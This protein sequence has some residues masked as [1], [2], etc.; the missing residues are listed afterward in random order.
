MRERLQL[1]IKR[2]ADGQ[3]VQQRLAVF[4]RCFAFLM[5]MAALTLSEPH[6][7]NQPGLLTGR[8][9]A[10]PPNT[11]QK[12]DTVRK[13]DAAQT[14]EPADKSELTKKPE[15]PHKTEQEETLDRDR[16]SFLHQV[17][18]F[19][20]WPDASFKQT[21]NDFVIAVLGQNAKPD[22]LEKLMFRRAQ[23]NNRRIVVKRF[24]DLSKIGAC[25]ILYITAIVKPETQLEA[26][27]TYRG[28]PVLVIGE[29]AEF[30]RNG[31]CVGLVSKDETVCKEF[32]TAE[33]QRQ[34]VIV[35]LRLQRDGVFVETL[36][37]KPDSPLP[38]QEKPERRNSPIP[39][40]EAPD[41]GAA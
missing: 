3:T 24:T 7:P 30:T 34:S 26:I 2:T 38:V 41:F 29:S 18:F 14:S 9:L 1:L 10:A 21:N 35:D 28:K 22:A 36:P 6:S 33:I 27:R 40:P 20:S 5:G 15:Q 39:A 32:N 17:V 31:G 4:R 16:C 23:A 8:L 37:Q 19:C 13:S 12:S 25:Q 11:D